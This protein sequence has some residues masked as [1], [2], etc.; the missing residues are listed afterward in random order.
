MWTRA[1]V[2]ERLGVKRRC[3]NGT[4]PVQAERSEKG[5]RP[6][7]TARP[8]GRSMGRGL[9]PLAVFAKLACID[10][11]SVRRSCRI[12]SSDPPDSTHSR[13]PRPE[14]GGIVKREPRRPPKTERQVYPCQSRVLPSALTKAF[15]AWIQTRRRNGP[16]SSPLEVI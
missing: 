10:Y 3:C 6:H 8:D 5:I 12:T 9:N 15:E 14:D 4:L 2:P 13:Q 7:G 11:C 1:C 16:V